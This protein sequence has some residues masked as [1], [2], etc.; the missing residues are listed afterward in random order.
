LCGIAAIVVAAGPVHAQGRGVGGLGGGF[1]AGIGGGLGSGVG[2]GMGGSMGLGAG[3]DFGHGS[4]SGDAALG[5]GIDRRDTARAGRLSD[6]RASLTGRSHADANAGFG[7]GASDQLS[8]SERHDAAR[9]KRHSYSADDRA[10][11]VADA[12][13]GLAATSDAGASAERR[14]TARLNRHAYRASDTAKAKANPEAGLAAATMADSRAKATT[15][16]AA[17]SKRHSYEANARART[18]AD[19]NAGME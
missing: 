4:M 19:A 16:T 6:E 9:T 17:R 12:N 15:R 14:E 10:R 8:G 13:A 11:A 2:G 7:L 3:G 1:G 18:K 5:G